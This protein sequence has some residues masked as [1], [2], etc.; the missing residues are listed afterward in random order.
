MEFSG[1]KDHWV[2]APLVV[3]DKLFAVNSDGYLY[4]LDLTGWTI[5]KRRQ[6]QSNWMGVSGRNLLQMASAFMLHRSII[7]SSL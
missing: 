2:A 4:V 5:C 1:A 3:K 6:R 7:V